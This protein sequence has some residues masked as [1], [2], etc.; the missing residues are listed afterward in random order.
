MND[1]HSCNAFLKSRRLS[2]HGNFVS[3]QRFVIAAFSAVTTISCAL[4]VPD[5][6]CRSPLSISAITAKRSWQS[7]S[8]LWMSCSR[9]SAS[10]T[11]SLPASALGKPCS[12]RKQR[13]ICSPI[14]TA[15][16]YRIGN[17]VL[18]FPAAS[19]YPPITTP[20]GE[21][22][23]QYWPCLKTG[24]ENAPKISSLTRV[25][26]QASGKKVEPSPFA[27]HAPLA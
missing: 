13:I 23:S 6:C 9:N 25:F 12:S 11:H 1:P 5:H 20:L 19:R 2:T 24:F 21:T 18:I 16:H 26:D 15:H 8:P 7:D 27:I 14:I 3:I 10:E 4:P 17:A 22:P